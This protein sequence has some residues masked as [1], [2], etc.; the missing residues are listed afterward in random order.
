MKNKVNSSFNLYKAS[1]S[2][3]SILIEEWR[4]FLRGFSEKSTALTQIIY[5]FNAG[6]N[7][8]GKTKLTPDQVNEIFEE[9]NAQW[10]EF[11]ALREQ[12]KIAIEEVI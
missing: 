4:D 5:N 11:S 10:S 1:Q 3:P 9:L 6:G 8:F 7:A 2:D 12:L